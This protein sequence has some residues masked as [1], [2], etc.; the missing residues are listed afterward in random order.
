MHKSINF[1]LCKQSINLTKNANKT[2]MKE[3]LEAKHIYIYGALD[4]IKIY[5]CGACHMIKAFVDINFQF[6]Y[7]YYLDY[8]KYIQSSKFHTSVANI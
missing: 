6:S 3:N 4:R 8:I 2:F 7:L 1:L 5:V